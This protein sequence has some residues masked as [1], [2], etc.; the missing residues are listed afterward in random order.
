MQE[1]ALFYRLQNY[2]PQQDAT[3]YEPPG[4]ELCYSSSIIAKNLQEAAN[5][6]TDVCF[7]LNKGSIEFDVVY[8]MLK[9]KHGKTHVILDHPYP[10]KTSLDEKVA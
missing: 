6:G 5:K 1:Y 9:T 8:A 3:Y 2:V 4:P 10:S 7:E